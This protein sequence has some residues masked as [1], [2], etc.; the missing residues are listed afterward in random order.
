MARVLR[1]SFG[2]VAEACPTVR[3]APLSASW[4]SVPR[5]KRSAFRSGV[6]RGGFS[7]PRQGGLL[8]VWEDAE[9]FHDMLDLVKAELT[10]FLLHALD[11]HS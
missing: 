1:V 11:C 10:K 2:R 6:G 7:A 4:K 8:L 3:L 9:K 5:P